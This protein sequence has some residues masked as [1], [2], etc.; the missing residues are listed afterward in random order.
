MIR[1]GFVGNSGV[2]AKRGCVDKAKQPPAIESAKTRRDM[3]DNFFMR[4][5]ILLNTDTQI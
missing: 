5:P 2:C 4:L 3:P 1:T